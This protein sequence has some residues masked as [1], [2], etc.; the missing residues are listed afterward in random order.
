MLTRIGFVLLSGCSF[1]ASCNTDNNLNMDKAQSFVSDA[2]EQY[3]GVKPTKVSCPENVKAKTGAEVVCIAEVAGLSAKVTM[4]QTDSTG[5]ITLE[6]MTG[7]VA[8]SKIEDALES[9]IKGQTQKSVEVDCGARVHPSK[10][11]DVLTCDVREAQAAVAR[12]LV[13]IKDEANNVAFKVVPVDDAA[14]APPEAP[15]P[16]PETQGET[17]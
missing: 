9:Q 3:T 4:K 16:T 11:G 8:S 15:A 13:T 10:P 17:P 5:S 14:A 12:V 1:K 6:S 2:V 7:I